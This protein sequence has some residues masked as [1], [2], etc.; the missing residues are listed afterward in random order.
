MTGERGERGSLISVLVTLVQ[1][2]KMEKRWK[3]THGKHNNNKKIYYCRGGSVPLVRVIKTCVTHLESSHGQWESVVFF[4]DDNVI[5]RNSGTGRISL[6]RSPRAA[7]AWR[8]E[9]PSQ[10]LVSRSPNLT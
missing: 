9:S 7:P 2:R 3:T 1:L 5:L 6:T 10:V 8:N 4:F